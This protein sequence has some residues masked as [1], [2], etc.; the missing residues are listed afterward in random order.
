LIEKI[1]KLLEEKGFLDG[2][3]VEEMLNGIDIHREAGE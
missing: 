1:A 3:E 2:A